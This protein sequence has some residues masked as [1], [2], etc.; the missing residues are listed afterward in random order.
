MLRAFVYAATA[1]ALFALDPCA[2]IPFLSPETP[3]PPLAEPPPNQR[4]IRHMDDPIT[5]STIAAAA[6]AAAGVLGKALVDKFKVK[7]TE[8][9]ADMDGANAAWQLLFREAKKQSDTNAAKIVALEVKSD[10]A[11]KRSDKCEEQH[12]ECEKKYA[13]L[14]HRVSSLTTT[15]CAVKDKVDSQS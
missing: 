15:M 2:Q 14:E 7:R 11:E 3:E 1:I 8:D 9:R 13:A 6:G 12:A 10:L 4:R 5:T